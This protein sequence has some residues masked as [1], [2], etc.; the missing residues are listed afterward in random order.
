[1][2]NSDFAPF[3]WWIFLLKMVDLSSSFY[4]HV[5]QRVSWVCHILAFGGG[6]VINWWYMWEK[7]TSYGWKL[8]VSLTQMGNRQRRTWV[9]TETLELLS[10][11]KNESF[12]RPLGLLEGRSPSSVFICFPTWTLKLPSKIDGQPS[13]TI[14]LI[15]TMWSKFPD[16]N[17]SKLKLLV[18]FATGPYFFE[19]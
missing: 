16:Q 13:P 9:F 6:L 19:T 11:G 15:P 10:L 17:C 14:R 8:V 5:Y 3:C 1:M 2:A 12:F 4:V 7:E 18:I